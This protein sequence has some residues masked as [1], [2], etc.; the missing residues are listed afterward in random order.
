MK[1]GVEYQ[2]GLMV[3]VLGLVQLQRKAFCQRLAPSERAS[4]LCLLLD[5]LLA[6]LPPSTLHTHL[7]SKKNAVQLMTVSGYEGSVPSLCLV[8]LSAGSDPGEG[9]VLGLARQP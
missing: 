9:A 3:Y 1:A 2:L 7:V 5:G 8:I 4:A 6:P